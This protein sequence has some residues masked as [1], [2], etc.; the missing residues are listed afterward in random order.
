MMED[1]H[2]IGICSQLLFIAKNLERIG[3]HATFIA[4]M[5]YYVVEGTPLAEDRPKG[6][7]ITAA[8]CPTTRHTPGE[9]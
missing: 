4:E 7:A 6:E 1:P 8:R 5:T 9:A 3:D 2:L